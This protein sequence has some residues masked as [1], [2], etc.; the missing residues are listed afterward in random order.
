MELVGF[1]A[2]AKRGGKGEVVPSRSLAGGEDRQGWD[3]FTL[4]YFLLKLKVLTLLFV[5]SKSKVRKI[6]LK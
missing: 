1:L 5:K 2:A 4:L 3:Y 6:R